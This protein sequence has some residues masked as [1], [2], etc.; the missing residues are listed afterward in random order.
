MIIII[1]EMIYNGVTVG[2]SGYTVVLQNRCF[3]IM[4]YTFTI[5]VSERSAQNSMLGKLQICIYNVDD[6]FNNEKIV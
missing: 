3:I 1:I 6:F 5:A 4:V 2:S